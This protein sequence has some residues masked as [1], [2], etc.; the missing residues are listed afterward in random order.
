M[1]APRNG[2]PAMQ[3]VVSLDDSPAFSSLQYSGSSHISGDDNLRV[4]LEAKLRKPSAVEI[5]DFVSP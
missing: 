1:E 4:R 3:L 2:V 5:D